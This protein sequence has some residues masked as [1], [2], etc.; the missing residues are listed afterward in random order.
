MWTS[1]L[2]WPGVSTHDPG[3]GFDEDLAG[4][5]RFGPGDRWPW[6][7]IGVSAAPA[8]LVR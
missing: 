3:S 2:G 8:P 7:E 4:G 5:R 1:S 6:A